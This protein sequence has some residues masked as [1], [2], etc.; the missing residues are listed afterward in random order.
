M[1]YTPIHEAFADITNNE[2]D[3][4]NY[5]L[6][7][8]YNINHINHINDTNNT[9]NTNHIN[10]MNNTN[11]TNHINDMNNMNEIKDSNIIDANRLLRDYKKLNKSLIDNKNFYKK[12]EKQKDDITNY[13]CSIYLKH[14]NCLLQ[15]CR[16]NEIIELNE[17]NEMNDNI[18]KYIDLFKN[19]SDKWNNEYYTITKKKLL[20]DIENQETKLASFRKI[21]VNTTNEIISPEKPN[22]NLCPICFENEINMCAIPCGHTFCN[23][24]IMQS[25][26]YHNNNNNKKCLS[27]RNSLKEYIKIYISL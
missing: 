24:C 5:I 10:D 4:S 20:E 25:S 27:C 21:F 26:T 7:T 22:K 15:M 3:D 14:Q 23:N 2:I 1:N 11:N 12:L 9:N 8:S 16:N 13:K 19:Y 17:T 18:I 6:D